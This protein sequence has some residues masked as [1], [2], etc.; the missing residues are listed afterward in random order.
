MQFSLNTLED[1]FHVWEIKQVQDDPLIFA[2][3]L[4]TGNSEKNGVSDLSSCSSDDHTLGL[5]V[6]G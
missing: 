2:Q 4:T 3:E 6:A 5:A 1:F